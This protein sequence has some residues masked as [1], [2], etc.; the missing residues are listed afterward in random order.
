M[1]SIEITTPGWFTT[2]QDQGRTA[3]QHMGVPV[4]GALDKFSAAMAN[5]LV[6][7]PIHSA[8][9]EITVMGPVF[10]LNRE[11]DMALAGADME[12]RV[13]QSLVP[14]WETLRLKP[15][16]KV[17]LGPAQKGC[18]AYLAFG[19][20][21]IVPA[22]MGSFSTLLG[23]KM[24]GF[25]G[26]ALKK[27][28]VLEIGETP[29]LKKPRCLPLEFRPDLGAPWIFR[30][31]PGPQEEYFNPGH[32]FGSPYQVTEK[33]D[34]MGYRLSGPLV[35]IRLEFPQS[36][37]SEPVM[38]GSIQ[39]PSDFQPI[40][41]LNEQTVGGYAKIATLIS[42]DLAKVAQAMPGDIVV[43]E[44]ID[45]HAAHE[46]GRREKERIQRITRLF[47]G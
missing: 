23:G 9:L 13:N 8:L 39:I 44:K 36:I 30:A 46:L 17:S 35:P 18:R 4:S 24:G 7:N 21:I 15:G 33:A 16:D 12:I 29:L 41:L 45:L 43:I 5:L 25:K 2:V 37:I 10:T 11:M 32:L 42:L 38:P 40:I 1:K 22:V 27:S 20:G 47:P 6:G 28:D 3:F 19:G 31:V 14:S 34:R 26:R